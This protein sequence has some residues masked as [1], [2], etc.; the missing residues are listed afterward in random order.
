MK[1]FLL[2]IAGSVLIF[3]SSYWVLFSFFPL[4]LTVHPI[5]GSVVFT[6]CL[7]LTAGGLGLLLVGVLSFIYSLL[8]FVHFS[9]AYHPRAR[10]PHRVSLTFKAKSEGRLKTPALRPTRPRQISRTS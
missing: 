1:R 2:T 6:L 10:Y 7:F 4:A 9:Y 5:L 8:G 3:A